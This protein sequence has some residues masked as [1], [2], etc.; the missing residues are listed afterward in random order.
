LDGG[1]GTCGARHNPPAAGWK[2]AGPSVIRS[3]FVPSRRETIPLG[4][5]CGLFARSEQ[6][7]KRA[8]GLRGP[9]ADRVPGY[10]GIR[11]P[12]SGLSPRGVLRH[13]PVLRMVERSD[14]DPDV[15]DAVGEKGNRRTAIAAEASSGEVRRAIELQLA[16]GEPE[17]RAGDSDRR[18][19]ET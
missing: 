12:M 13:G 3:T 8:R 9:I 4:S 14:L 17:S 6:P 5:G 1:A 11:M 10:L 15:R 19:E 16:F 2:G 7:I 18:A